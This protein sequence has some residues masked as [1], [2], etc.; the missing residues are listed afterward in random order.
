[1]RARAATVRRGSIPGVSEPPPFVT[2]VRVRY[3]ETDQMGVVHHAAYLHY[4]EDA[5]TA[6]L[7]ALGLPYSELERGGIGLPVRRAELRYR[8]P[9]RYEDEL[10]VAVRVVR[11]RGASVTFAYTVTRADGTAIAEAEVELACIEL[12]SGRPRLLPDEL[13]AHFA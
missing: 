13:R 11:L 8:A 1:M 10:D 6:W 5:R 2:R 12:A 7:R 9:A 4:L 3:G